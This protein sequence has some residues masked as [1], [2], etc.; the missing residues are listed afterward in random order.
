MAYD[1]EFMSAE[2]LDGYLRP[3]R[4]IGSAAAMR[5]MAKHGR[6]DEVVDI[7]NIEAPTLLI[8]GERD[9]AVKLAVGRELQQSIPHACLEIVPHAGHLPLEEHPELCNRLIFDFIGDLGGP[10]EFAAPAVS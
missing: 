8:W 1:R 4:V 7:V 2:V 10:G 3:T 9:R 5:K 6:Q